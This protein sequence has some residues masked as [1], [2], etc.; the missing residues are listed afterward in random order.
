M[1]SLTVLAGPGWPVG[2]AVRR[3]LLRATFRGP[4]CYVPVEVLDPASRRARE[5]YPALPAPARVGHSAPAEA[6][7]GLL[8]VDDAGRVWRGDRAWV[9]LLWA[10]GPPGGG[11]GG[12]AGG[13][14]ASEARRIVEDLATGRAGGGGDARWERRIFALTLLG[15]LAAIVPSLSLATR[16]LGSLLLIFLALCLAGRGVLAWGGLLALSVWTCPPGSPLFPLTVTIAVPVLLGALVVRAA[17]G[18][19]GARPKGESRRPADAG[20]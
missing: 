10:R 19:G 18:R 20:R 4:S 5:R 13:G 11:G 15:F 14:R 9:T 6:D 16:E 12:G 7:P 8:V 2:S 17:R 1:R 3:G